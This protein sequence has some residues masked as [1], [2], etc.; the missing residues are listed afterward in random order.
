MTLHFSPPA[1]AARIVAVYVSRLA[2]GS[3]VVATTASIS[4]PYP[5]E[6]VRDEWEAGTGTELWNYI[7]GELG[8][9]LGT[10]ETVTPAGL[11]PGPCGLVHVTGAAGR[12]A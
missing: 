11:V 1:E 7:A 12:K 5:A 8:A 4:L 2:P 3:T 6:L 10:L 9:V